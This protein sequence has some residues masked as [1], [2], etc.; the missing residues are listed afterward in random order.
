MNDEKLTQ[1]VRIHIDRE[2]YH[3]SN[4]TTGSALYH[5][6]KINGHRELF[7]ETEGN[8]EDELVPQDGTNIRLHQDEHFYSQVGFEIIVNARR[9]LV[10]DRRVTFEQVVQLAFPGTHGANIVFS[11]TYR[12]AAS[13]PH[14]GE[15]GAGGSVEVK[16]KG[17]IFNV[18]RTD[19]S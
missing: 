7:R 4:P 2:L 8:Q 9:E 6:A 13:K 10:P 16:R 12:H 14:A 17:T 3:S 5:L 1:E 18:T 19:K 11:V 15:L